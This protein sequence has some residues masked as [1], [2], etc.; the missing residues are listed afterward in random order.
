VGI[1]VATLGRSVRG[2]NSNQLKGKGFGLSLWRNPTQIIS[3]ILLLIGQASAQELTIWHEIEPTAL[4][5]GTAQAT[6]IRSDDRGIRTTDTLSQMISEKTR[7]EVIS[8]KSV[9]QEF[10]DQ[11]VDQTVQ[12]GVEIRFTAKD[13]RGDRWVT[14]LSSTNTRQDISQFGDRANPYLFEH[15][16]YSLAHG[17]QTKLTDGLT[18]ELFA[19]LA[20]CQQADRGRSRYRSVGGLRLHTDLGWARLAASLSQDVEGGGSLSSVYGSQLS[21]RAELHG[22]IPIVAG[23]SFRWDCGVSLV[24]GMFEEEEMVRHAPVVVASASL[25]FEISSMVRGSVGYT[26]RKMLG[27][28]GNHGVTG[29]MATAALTVQLF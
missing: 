2:K 4:N 22:S 8:V 15:R 21:R 27:G 7:V 5:S 17:W 13:D 9:S 24:R 11:R 3:V 25:E 20:Q 28:R 23:L 10:G 19:G 12:R 6:D 1:E 16:T 29:P 26:H 14:R 18:L